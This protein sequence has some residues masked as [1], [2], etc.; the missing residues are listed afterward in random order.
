MMPLYD[1][2]V[3]ADF[4]VAV[5]LLVVAPLILLGISLPH[6][7]IRDRLLAYWR[8]SALL[9]ITVY[10]W[11]DEA[12]LGFVTGYAARAIL[13]V[14]LWWGDALTKTLGR[15]HPSGD[16]WPAALFRGWRLVATAYSAAGLVYMLPLLPCAGADASALCQAWYLPPQEYARL[17]HP[18][19]AWSVLGTYGRAALAVYVGY[20]AA[21]A[22]VLWTQASRS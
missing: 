13:P 7:E 8:A 14:A 4:L 11:I 22:Y 19:T 15:S 17:A 18:Y 5:G 20:A 2:L 6:P 1:T 10:V 12:A 16:G 9:G 21:S 3:R